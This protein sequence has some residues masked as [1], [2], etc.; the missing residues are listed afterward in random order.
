MPKSKF[1]DH[2]PEEWIE[3]W[4]ENKRSVLATMYR[5]LTADIE[6]KYCPWGYSARQSQAQITAYIAEWEEQ[7]MMLD[8]YNDSEKLRAI[9]CFGWL[10]RSGAVE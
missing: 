2:T 3:M 7:Q 4:E 6:A 9:D 10:K 1:S 8:H 5:N